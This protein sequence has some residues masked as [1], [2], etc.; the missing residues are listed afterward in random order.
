MDPRKGRC[1]DS[2]YRQSQ[3]WIGSPIREEV[4]KVPMSPPKLQ[5]IYATTANTLSSRLVR[6][7]VSWSQASCCGQEL[8]SLFLWLRMIPNE[9]IQYLLL[10]FYLFA[11]VVIIFKIKLK[12]DQSYS[13]AS[14]GSLHSYSV[15]SLIQSMIP[16]LS[17]PPLKVMGSADLSFPY[18]KIVG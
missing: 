17:L 9:L 4:R 13:S 6:P 1:S 5:I 15:W 8:T 3:W 16:A 7:C 11:I 14:W 10:I 2:K 12:E 18:Q